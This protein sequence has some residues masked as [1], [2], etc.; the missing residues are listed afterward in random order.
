M[1]FLSISNMFIF[2]FFYFYSSLA[3]SHPSKMQLEF[4]T[5][6]YGTPMKK[7]NSDRLILPEQIAYWDLDPIVA[8]PKSGDLPDLDNKY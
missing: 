8:K 4:I 6:L 7:R 1:I 5:Y 3:T 2:P